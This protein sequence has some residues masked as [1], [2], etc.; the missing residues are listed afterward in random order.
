[1]PSRALGAGAPYADARPDG[2]DTDWSA[3]QAL[4]AGPGNPTWVTY[5]LPHVDPSGTIYTTLTN[6]TPKKGF[7]CASVLVD[8]STD[9]GKTWS[10]AETAVSS[11][12]PPPAIYPNTRRAA[13]GHPPRCSR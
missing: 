8:K 3:P 11:V 9:G 10:V 12:T 5:V 1:L 6:F 13:T 2:T 7:C 4:P